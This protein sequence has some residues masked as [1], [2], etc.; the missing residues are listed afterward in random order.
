MKNSENKSLDGIKRVVK[1]DSTVSQPDPNEQVHL[2]E[3]NE[4]VRESLSA[5]EDDLDDDSTNTPP[6]TLPDRILAN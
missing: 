6:P 2:D 3:L 4:D 5:L 1:D